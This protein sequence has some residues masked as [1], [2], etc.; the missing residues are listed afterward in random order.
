MPESPTRE[1]NPLTPTADGYHF[2]FFETFLVF[3][4]V[5]KRL[6]GGRTPVW[7]AARDPFFAAL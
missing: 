2:F 3:L 4:A 7:R 1:A 5:L 6:G